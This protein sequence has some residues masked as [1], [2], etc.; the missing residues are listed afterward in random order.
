M[1]HLNK[2]VILLISTLF[3]AGCDNS[4]ERADK[5]VSLVQEKVTSIVNELTEIQLAEGNLQAEFESTIA[6]AGDDLTYFASD[7]SPIQQNIQRRKEHLTKLEEV[8]GE[9]DTMIE[10]FSN[11]VDNSPLP[12]EQ[13]TNQITQLQELSQEIVTYI[14]DYRENIETESIVYKSIANPETDY[15]SF[16]AVFDR[17]SQLHT[18]NQINLER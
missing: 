14:S 8:R 11:Q 13:V 15:S 3:I 18:T 17:V 4:L 6:N 10:E 5:T 12:T 9:L 16:F 7:D 1:K 2:I